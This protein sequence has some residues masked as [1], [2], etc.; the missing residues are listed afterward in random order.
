VYER[1]VIAMSNLLPEKWSEALERV[2][3]GGVEMRDIVHYM[4]PC[5]PFSRPLSGMVVRRLAYIFD[6]RHDALEKHFGLRL[7][8]Q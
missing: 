1:E 2:H 4:L 6:Y 5:D 7:Q 8:E 3:D